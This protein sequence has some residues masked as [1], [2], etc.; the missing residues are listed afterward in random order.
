MKRHLRS[1]A[2]IACALALGSVGAAAARHGSHGEGSAA[3]ARPAIWRTYD[4]IV[5]FQSLPRTYTCDQLW[6]E[7]RGILLRLGARASSI[8]VL[9]YDC[10]PTP[11]GDMKSPNVQVRFQLPFFLLPGVK[12]API[13]AVEGTVRFSPGKPKTLRASDCQLLQ[14]IEQ[15]MFAS[16]PV[17]VDAAHFDCSAPP[18]RSGKFAVTLSIP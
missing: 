1:I 5:S 2:A 7:F 12:G 16:M 9:P 10:S 18:P 8:N 11:S 6:Y 17:K 3:A 14:H 4:M 13:E 15:T